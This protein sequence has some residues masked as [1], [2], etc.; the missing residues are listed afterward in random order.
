MPIEQLIR[1]IRE[2]AKIWKLKARYSN[3]TIKMYRNRASISTGAEENKEKAVAAK[4]DAA[5]KDSSKD[6]SKDDP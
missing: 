4:Q 3:D 1:D 6:F 2:D 5:S